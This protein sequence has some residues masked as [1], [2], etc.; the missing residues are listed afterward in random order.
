MTNPQKIPTQKEIEEAKERIRKIALKNLKA[1]NL[2]N[3]ASA[4]LVEESGVYGEA[5]GSAVQEFKYWPSFDSALKSNDL[6]SGEERNLYKESILASRQGAGNGKPGK[7]YSGSFKEYDIMQDC[8]GI[9]QESL[10][11]IKV[12]DLYSELMGGDKKVKEE[13]KDIY[14][15]ELRPQI[16][17]EEFS[18]LPENKQKGIKASQELYNTL[19]AAYQ[20]YLTDKTVSE[21]LGERKV[22]NL[23]N[24]EKILIGD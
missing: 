24:L 2:M 17:Q 5:G 13:L 20:T 22:Q 10:D 9:M 15:G 14:L 4:F 21:S 7:R 8:A 6:K 12:S 11:K 19:T 3:L 18:K 16:S 23:K 1:G